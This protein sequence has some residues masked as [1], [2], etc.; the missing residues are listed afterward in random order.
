MSDEH[1]PMVG[2]DRSPEHRIDPVTQLLAVARLEIGR[3]NV[4]SVVEYSDRSEAVYVHVQRAEHWYGIRIACHQAVY[5]CSLDY[6][7]IVLP[8]DSNQLHIEKAAPR[9][10]KAIRDGNAI[11]ANPAEVRELIEY[12]RQ[13]QA[14]GWKTVDSNGTRWRWNGLMRSWQPEQLDSFSASPPKFQPRA[15]L[16]H[17][18]C[19]S[20]RHRLNLIAKWSFDEAMKAS[21]KDWL[22]Q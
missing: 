12:T 2:T 3:C 15:P 9:L 10:T 13:R 14:H 18:E 5:A 4:E 8:S 17:L 20:L 6:Q 21:G 7:Q 22:E 11:V 1:S 16:S 19:S